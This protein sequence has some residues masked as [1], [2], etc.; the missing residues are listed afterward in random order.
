M[1]YQTH[2][3]AKV[4]TEMNPSSL[5]L[6]KNVSLGH[7]NVAA[8]VEETALPGEVDGESWYLPGG[9]QQPSRRFQQSLQDL[10]ECVRSSKHDCM[11]LIDLVVIKCWAIF[12]LYELL[13][14]TC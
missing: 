12:K 3:I 10:R 4:P 9:T 7:L 6:D 1:R 8:P 11:E 14:A 2:K 13:V 5:Y